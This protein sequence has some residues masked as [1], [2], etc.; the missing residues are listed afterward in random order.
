MQIAPMRALDACCDLLMSTEATDA[1][2]A[3][4]A[5][6]SASWRTRQTWKRVLSAPWVLGDR[7]ITDMI[8]DMILHSRNSEGKKKKKNKVKKERKKI[9]PTILS[10][11]VSGKY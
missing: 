7:D 4:A 9:K 5:T 3:R 6:R 1:A 10:K 2:R 11:D 8:I